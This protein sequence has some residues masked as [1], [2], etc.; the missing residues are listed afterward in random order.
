MNGSGYGAVE[1]RPSAVQVPQ[2]LKW[3]LLESDWM[4]PLLRRLAVILPA[5][6]RSR[7]YVAGVQVS[8]MSA[9]W[10]ELHERDDDKHGAPF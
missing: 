10:L 4:F 8:P 9:A 5:W 2:A 6:R 3:S 7:R 1:S